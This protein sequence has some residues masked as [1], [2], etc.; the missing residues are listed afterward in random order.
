MFRHVFSL[1]AVQGSSSAADLPEQR[2]VER[3][4]RPPGVGRDWSSEALADVGRVEGEPIG[5]EVT[6]LGGGT[7]GDSG[8]GH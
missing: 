2:T 1:A 5:S 3:G 7:A 8:S 6:A 4:E